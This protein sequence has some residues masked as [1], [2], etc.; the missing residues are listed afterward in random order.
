MSN[1]NLYIPNRNLPVCCKILV[2]E[3]VMS[4][5]G[6]APWS[7]ENDFSC[8]LTWEKEGGLYL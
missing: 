5:V 4:L 2:L 3:D 7:T 8:V 6:P 1:S